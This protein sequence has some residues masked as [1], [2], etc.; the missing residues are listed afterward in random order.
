MQ[1]DL[2]NHLLAHAP[3]A[4]LVG[5]RINWVKRAQGEGLPAIA[6]HGV[7]ARKE[8]H[9]KGTSEVVET[10]VQIDIFAQSYGSADAVARVVDTLL[11]GLRAQI[12]DTFFC[13]VFFDMRRE[14][15]EDSEAEKLFRISLDY[16]LKHK[17]FAQ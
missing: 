16:T 8:P 1:V 9:Q 11:T 15:F 2:L 13:G 7:G 5:A 3:L 10:R 14:G 6:L 17:E 12:G 4:A